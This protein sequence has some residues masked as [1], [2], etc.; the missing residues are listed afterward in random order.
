VEHAAHPAFQDGACRAHCLH[1][2]RTRLNILSPTGASPASSRPFAFLD[3]DGTIIVDR[4]YLCEP[5]RVELCAGAAEGL[6]ALQRAGF[7][8]I[9]ITNQSGIGRGYFDESQLFA[10]DDRLCKMLQTHN[11]HLEAIYYCP[12][13]PGDGC[14]CR[15]PRPGL[16]LRAVSQVGGD[17]RGACVIGDNPADLQLARNLGLAAIYVTTGRTPI[18]PDLLE[19]QPNFRADS[20]A[21]AANF[22]LSRPLPP[23]PAS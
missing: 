23:G 15:K 20:L 19:P 7:R 4:H 5:D 17:L 11:I 22:I 10:V 3:R 14:D 1:Y 8:L 6:F 21:A 9:V 2:C 12:H 18:A 16:V 13:A